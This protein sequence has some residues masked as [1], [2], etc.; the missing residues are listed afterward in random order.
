MR[1]RVLISLALAIAVSLAAVPVMAGETAYERYDETV[2]LT[3][4]KRTDPNA[5]F[6][7]GDSLDN[8]VMTRYI[9]DRIN[10][11][12]K[13]VWEVDSTEFNN[14][15]S[16]DIVAGTL[17][18]MFS[19]GNDDYL[20][21]RQLLDNGLLADLTDAYDANANWYLRDTA[22]SFEGR[23]FAPYTDDGRLMGIPTG[24]YGYEHNQLWLRSDIL[25]AI[26]MKAEEILTIAD[27]ETYLTKAK[28][29]F[30]DTLGLALHATDPLTN[31]ASSFSADPIAQVFGATPRYWIEG[32]DGSITY[33]SL[34]PGMKDALTVLADWYAK[35]LI[36]LE[37]PTRVG[38]GLTQAVT[39]SGQ[40][41][42]WFAPW[43]Y[44][45]SIVDLPK[46]V[47]GA[48]VVVV[49]AP[50]NDAGEFVAPWPSPAGEVLLVNKNCE[51]P[52]A[53]VRVMNLEYD[54]HRG[55]DEEAAAL[56]DESRNQNNP[57]YLDAS[58][59]YLFPT[60]GVN[61][62]YSNVV[63][64][65]S[66][67]IHAFVERGSQEGLASPSEVTESIGIGKFID[68]DESFEQYRGSYYARYVA[69]EITDAA[70]VRFVYPAYSQTTESMADIM[71]S[72]LTLEQQTVLQ[73]ILGQKSVDDFDAFTAQ[74]LAEGGQTLTDE[75][76]A[77]LGK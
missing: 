32:E 7:E 27:I 36:D 70:N 31:Y 39:T 53:V 44:G 52:E 3:T 41:A 23:H 14:K 57:T 38:G 67:G 71:P 2:V 43:W 62:E 74:W 73:I 77:L 48:D 34:L 11:E 19:L 35:G 4:V 69:G 37:F 54:M 28:E 1:K 20:I 5:K 15:L 16:L 50:V 58:W 51:H 61:M 12:T 65:F 64:T 21:Y 59:T 72:L 30:P 42:A 25:E 49:N 75:I 22:A 63:P 47:E 33:G 29:A 60:S 10:V 6:P 9:K 56:Y 45:W 40:A 68:G 18:D 8:N 46:N 13:T 76:S 55:F 66:H 26:G 24:R 17:P